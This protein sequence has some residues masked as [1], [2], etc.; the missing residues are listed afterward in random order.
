MSAQVH[1]TKLN[2]GK[3]ERLIESSLKRVC[4]KT[5]SVLHFV[6]ASAVFTGTT[7]EEIDNSR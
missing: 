5:G 6:S 2:E 4:I 3:L 7:L 1:M